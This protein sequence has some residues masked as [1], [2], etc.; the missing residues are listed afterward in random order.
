MLVRTNERDLLLPQE[1][2]KS[3]KPLAAVETKEDL[4]DKLQAQLEPGEEVLW[5]EQA[6][7]DRKL[8][9][10]IRI[11]AMAG[12]AV[13]LF[14]TSSLFLRD[15]NVSNFSV[16]VEIVFAFFA[17]RIARDF[18]EIQNFG[19]RNRIAVLTNLRALEVDS[20]DCSTLVWYS[21]PNFGHIEVI[22][23]KTGVGNVMFASNEESKRLGFNDVPNAAEAAKILL[24]YRP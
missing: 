13:L 15:G 20:N 6:V 22:E 5:A 7:P 1:F 21:S 3:T 10:L 4:L 2:E 14:L 17:F 8:V 11:G 24:R 9:M 16:V 19:L 23:K 18:F 12:T